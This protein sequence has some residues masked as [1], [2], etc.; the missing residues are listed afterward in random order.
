MKKYFACSDIHS[1]YDEWLQALHNAGFDL[2]NSEHIVVIC[3]DLFDRG[4]QS[5]KCYEFVKQL[6]EQNRLVY[7]RGNHEDL[8][9]DA[10]RCIDKRMYIG[11]HHV[12][13]GTLRTIADMIDVTEYDILCNSFEW[14]DLDELVNK[15]LCQFITDNT[16]D[17]FEL[18]K[19]IFV[20]GWV[21]TWNAD[22]GFEDV[23]E[24][25]AEGDWSKARWENG[26]EMFKF[27][28][29]PDNRNV[30]CGHWHASWG[31]AN[32]TKTH[33][34]WGPSAT[35][36][37]FT[38]YN[39]SRNSTIYALDACTVYSGSVNCLVFDEEGNVIND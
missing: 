29:V 17:Y 25:W 16:V 38:A 23:H 26:M 28:C 11:S 15:G 18:G 19:T 31:H 39:E 8:L 7:V 22:D 2:T 21:P 33:S 10:V 36:R 3:G 6:A 13:N 20:H 27:G 14:Q 5:K 37:T 24:D 32:I 9:F 12:S 30:V 34:E 4:H 1:F 35:F